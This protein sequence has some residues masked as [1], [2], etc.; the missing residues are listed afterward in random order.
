MPFPRRELSRPLPRHLLVLRQLAGA[1]LLCLAAGGAVA[2]QSGSAPLP[3]PGMVTGA[4]G[5]GQQMLQA[6]QLVASVATV[7]GPSQV[8]NDPVSR[9]LQ[10]RGL[11]QSAGSTK[12]LNQ[13]RDTAS[14][15][16][17]SA[18]NF[19]GVPYKRGGNSEENGF[20]CSGFTRYIFEMSVGMVLPH[21][22]EEQAGMSGLKNVRKDELKPGDLVFFNTMRRTFS[23]VGIYVGE[24]KF[25]H[26]PRTGSAVRVEDMREAYW[27]KRFTGARRANL[28]SGG[29]VP[30]GEAAGV[31]LTV[32]H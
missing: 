13:V 10:Q 9:F 17:L 29:S 30:V 19:L 6:Q 22:A 27:S 4:W 11:L 28:P 20:D 23:H 3:P 12:L 5:Q 31:G 15:L 18:M 32:A 8:S 21:R 16:V 26:A 1:A 24:G 2:Q 25:I 7:A 14:D